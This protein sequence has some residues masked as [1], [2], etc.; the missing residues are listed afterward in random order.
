MGKR[1]VDDASLKAIA[2]AMRS[3][4]GMGEDLKFPSGFIDGVASTYVTGHVHGTQEGYEDG[5]S[6]GE[7][8]GYIA[9]EADGIEQGIEQGIKQGKQAEYDRLWDTLQN[10]GD[11]AGANYYYKFSYSSNG[12]GWTDENFNP[13]YPI[14]CS[15]GATPGVALFYSN[16]AITDTK[17]PIEVLGSSAQSMFASAEKLVT[18]RKLT[19]HSGVSLTSAFNGCYALK[20]II[21]GGTIGTDLDIHWS[22]TTKASIESIMAALSTTTTGKSVSFSK[23]AVNNSFTDEEWATLANTRSNWTINLV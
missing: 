3:W 9:G 7:H 15:T 19:V 1:V 18:I 5:F 6:D 20:N 11:A 22:T 14:I 13:K 16:K 8:D 23:T 21:I 10:N 12:R 4:G 2:D 17:V